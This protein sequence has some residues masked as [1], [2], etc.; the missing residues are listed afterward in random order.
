MAEERPQ[1][2]NIFVSNLCRQVK[3]CYGDGGCH[4]NSYYGDCGCYAV[5]NGYQENGCH[6]DCCEGNLVRLTALVKPIVATLV[7]GP[8]EDRKARLVLV[9]Q[10]DNPFIVFDYFFVIFC[11]IFTYSFLNLLFIYSLNCC[12]YHTNILMNK[13]LNVIIIRFRSS[14]FKGFYSDLYNLTLNQPINEGSLPRT[15]LL[16]Y[17]ITLQPTNDQHSKFARSLLAELTSQ[18]RDTLQLSSRCYGNSVLHRRKQRLVSAIFF[19]EPWVN[20]V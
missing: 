13:K 3:G 1:L 18:Y 14:L 8:L 7:F 11:S 6:G 19:L 20:N 2:L 16:N 9:W 4:V 12:C 5:I 15:R 17:I 10:E